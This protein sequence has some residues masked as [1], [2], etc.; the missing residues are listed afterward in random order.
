MTSHELLTI[1]Y[2]GTTLPHVLP[3]LQA[4]WTE[5][6][7]DVRAA[8]SSRKPGFSKNLLAGSMAEASIGYPHLQAPGTPKKGRMAVRA[9]HPERMHIIFSPT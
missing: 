1:G 3:V 5:L 2:K 7:I 9:G 8:T 6:L 4:A